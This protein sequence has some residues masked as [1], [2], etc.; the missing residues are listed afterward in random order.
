MEE[1]VMNQELVNELG[2]V[3]TTGK[4]NALGA[5][6]AIGLTIG[7]GVLLVKGTKALIKKIKEKKA[8]KAVETVESEP[9]VEA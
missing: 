6:I 4:G 7:A 9:I 8:A 5:V 2:E 3:E 1:Q